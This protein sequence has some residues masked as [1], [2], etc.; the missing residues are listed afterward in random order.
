MPQHLH[1]HSLAI[2]GT[3]LTASQFDWHVLVS[4]KVFIRDIVDEQWG[5]RR[6]RTYVLLSNSEGG[7]SIARC[8]HDRPVNFPVF[9]NGVRID[10]LTAE[11]SFRH[12]YCDLEPAVCR[13]GR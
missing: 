5:Q 10:G 13:H 3:S 8:C 2:F 9:A 12:R 4:V 6:F 7:M 1:Q 11:V